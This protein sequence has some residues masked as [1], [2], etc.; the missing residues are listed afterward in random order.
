MLYE[1]F[2]WAGVLY[3]STSRRERAR[4]ADDAHPSAACVLLQAQV[5]PAT[6]LDSH[7]RG[8]RRAHTLEGCTPTSARPHLDEFFPLCAV[9]SP[10]RCGLRKTLVWC[11]AMLVSVCA[12]CGGRC[13][14]PVS[15]PP[16]LPL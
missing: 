1:D 3:T 14:C 7:Y 4:D 15:Y 6:E 8:A 11:V 16:R 10:R 2:L 12:L 5:F 13:S 9:S